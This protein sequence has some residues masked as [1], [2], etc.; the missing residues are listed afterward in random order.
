MPALRVLCWCLMYR[1]DPVL[2][3]STFGWMRSDRTLVALLIL[4]TSNSSFAP[5]RCALCSERQLLVFSCCMTGFVGS[6][7][8][9]LLLLISIGINVLVALLLSVFQI[10]KKRA[11]DKADGKLWADVHGFLY[12]EVSALTGDGI[13]DLFQVNIILIK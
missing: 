11:V 2:T 13:D 9:R 10:D 12:F 1:I 3:P 4:T 8:S 6:K 7:I 5:T